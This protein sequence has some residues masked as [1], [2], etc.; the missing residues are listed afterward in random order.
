MPVQFSIADSEP[1]N[2]ES[3]AYSHASSIPGSVVTSL[4]QTARVL[5]VSPVERHAEKP[6]YNLY[7]GCGA[8]GEVYKGIYNGNTVALKVLRCTGAVRDIDKHRKRLS[9][10]VLAFG[11]LS[12]PNV[13]PFLGLSHSNCELPSP[14]I[15][16]PWM[17]NGNID[18]Y[19]A[20]NPDANRLALVIGIAYGLEYLHS[21]GVIHGDLH[22]RNILINSDGAPMLADFGMSSS[23]GIEDLDISE[24]LDRVR[25]MSPELVEGNVQQ[26]TTMSDVFSFASV[27]YEVLTNMHPYANLG[28]VVEIILALY[29]GGLPFNHH[30]TRVLDSVEKDQSLWE[31]MSLSWNGV[32]EDRPSMNQTRDALVKIQAGQSLPAFLARL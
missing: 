11:Q 32:P 10:E 13:L 23:E 29:D 21:R 25:Y 12:H 28:T 14:A 19:M 31:L 16:S 4:Q 18:Q 15:V 9:R 6:S 20:R 27:C 26:P 1:L 2:R 7:S 17:K 5:V 24:G 3:L 30:K 22:P 8:Y